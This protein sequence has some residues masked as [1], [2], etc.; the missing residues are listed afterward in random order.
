M[1]V[2][3]HELFAESLELALNMEGYGVRRVPTASTTPVALLAGVARYQPRVV[4][5]DLDLGS[6]GDG[7]RLINPI[8]RTGSNVVVVTGSYEESEWGHCIKRGARKVIPKTHPLNEI[9]SVTRRICQGLPV[10]DAAERERLIGVWSEHRRVAEDLRGRLDRLTPR[11][12]EVLGWLVE[13]H[14]VREIARESVV[15]E[16]TVRTQVKRILRKLE[17]TSQLAAVGLARQAGWS[18]NVRHK[19]N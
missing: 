19:A 5:L 11:E 13:G 4:L 8:A 15:S 3:D 6:L 16:A 9:L 2:D 17:V 1:I 14:Q 10:M 12:A 7:T 18:P